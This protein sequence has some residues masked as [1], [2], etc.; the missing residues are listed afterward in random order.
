MKKPFNPDDFNTFLTV[1]SVAERF[2]ILT[3]MNFSKVS[4]AEELI[5]L[6]Y[7]IISKPYEDKKYSDISDY[8][9][10]EV[11]EIV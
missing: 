11:D 7:E 10:I 6:N 8:Y 9:D 4:L 2:E 3:T 1:K 5:K